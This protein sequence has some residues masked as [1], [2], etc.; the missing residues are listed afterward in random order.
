MPA[1]N[2]ECQLAQGQIGRYLAGTDMS[3]EAVSQLEL[4]IAEC[5]DCTAFVDAKR[6][7][8]QELAQTRRAAVSI[9]ETPAATESKPAV[10]T[11]SSGGSSAVGRALVEAIRQKADPLAKETILESS[12]EPQVPRRTYW[13]ALG[14]SAAL[15]AVLLAM[16]HLAANPTALFG[17]RV[18]AGSTEG[19]WTPQAEPKRE[20][21]PNPPSD[22]DPFTAE[23]PID[24]APAI[25]SAAVE[26]APT[27]PPRVNPAASAQPPISPVTAADAAPTNSSTPKPLVPSTPEGPRTEVRAQRPRRPARPPVRRSTPPAPAGNSIRVYGPDGKPIK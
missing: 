7:S 15:G 16:S 9:P 8:L 25:E 19:A 3:S 14:Y 17:D 4:H 24:E 22:G 13:K 21:A 11:Q 26:A 10:Q 2:I 12:R 6:Q 27:D 20:L 23:P 18:G 1:K 5:P